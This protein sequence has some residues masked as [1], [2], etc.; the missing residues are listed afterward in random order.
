MGRVGII[1]LLHESNTFVER[2]TTLD[3][4]RQD[5]LLVGH[6]VTRRLAGSEHEVGGFFQGL[7]RHGLDA[8]P[9]LC[10]RAVPSGT[11][12]ADAFAWL[13]REMRDQ[14]DRAG[15]LDAILVAPHGATVSE[16]FPDAD[17]HWLSVLRDQVG[18]KLPIMGTFDPHANLSRRMVD[19]TTALIA[20]RTNPHLDQRQRG[21]EA[22][23][24]VARTLR[25]EVHPVQRAI[26][27]PMAI[28]IDAQQT[29]VPPCGPL[30]EL[31]ETVRHEAGILSISM[32]LGFPY[33]DVA[34][35]GSSV[36]VV[37][38]R[39]RSLA[40]AAAHKIARQMWR[41]RDAF[42]LERRGIDAAL[43]QAVQWEGPTCLLDMGDNVGG[44]SPAD[45]TLLAHAIDDRQIDRAVVAL[46]DPESV[47]TA[48]RAGV[49][50]RIELAIGG[51]TDRRHGTP[52]AAW[53]TVIHVGNGRFEE[54]EPRHGGFT[55]VDQG[56]VAVVRT[57]HGLTVLITSRRVPPFSIRQ[58]T[59]AGINPADFRLL[60]AK[61]VNAPLAAYAPFCRHLLRV[62]TPGATA[63]DM[64]RFDFTHRRRPMFPFERD[65]EWPEG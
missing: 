55:Q 44:G 49:G 27:P 21:M 13:V 6:D 9:L 12:R 5:L 41:R 62:D 57:D 16:R 29:D 60:V 8:V 54:P 52:L 24:L 4:F 25:G 22:A 45:G 17:G 7:D 33:A 23:A 42:R 28:P 35:M 2:P 59:S 51:K 20:Y 38:D 58:L 64:T 32:V 18:Q 30:Y 3:A 40:A 53:Y 11:I 39:D 14:L 61:G 1:A 46:Y 31:A 56:Q 19:A 15:P 26:F 48:D 10:A 43:D 34:E 50:A 63:A 65:A 47:R 37:A 36:L